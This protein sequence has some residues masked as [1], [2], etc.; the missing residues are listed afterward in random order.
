MSGL[1][2]I[3]LAAC[4]TT[5]QIL[6]IQPKLDVSAMPGRGAGKTL[7]VAVID[8]RPGQFI[9]YREPRDKS[10]AIT[11][12][13]EALE[14]IQRTI[15]TAYAELG[16]EVVAPGAAADVVLEVKLVELDYH[17]ERD[18]VIRNLRTA[19]TLKATSVLKTKTVKGTYRDAQAKETVIKPSL[20]EN[21]A[22]LN[23]HLD[24]AMLALVSDDRLTS[25]DW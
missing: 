15:E 17:L 20:Y 22:T 21:A 11:A 4:A 18:G 23:T 19:A 3:V 9:G 1:C 14:N 5:S 7:S 6:P 10:T 13:P 25:E 24:A 8:A 16:F 2:L 12:A